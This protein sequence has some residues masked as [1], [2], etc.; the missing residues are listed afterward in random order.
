VIQILLELC[1]M[2]WEYICV[3]GHTNE[4]EAH[5]YEKYSPSETNE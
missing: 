4:S 5:F 1:L 2:T 3:Y